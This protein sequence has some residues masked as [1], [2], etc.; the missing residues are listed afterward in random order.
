MDPITFGMVSVGIAGG[1]LVVVS[2]L[3][4]YDVKVN[5]TMIKIVLE[6]TKMGGILY[7]LEHLSKIFF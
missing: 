4:K 6:L 5:E 3:E 1:S 7:L 2:I